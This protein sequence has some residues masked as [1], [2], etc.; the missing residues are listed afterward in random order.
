MS[1][2][3]FHQRTSR[4]ALALTALGL[5]G[6]LIGAG[7]GGANTDTLANYCQAQAEAECSIAVVQACYGSSDATLN[8][9][10]SSCIQTRSAISKCNPS[11]LPYHPEQA[12]NCIDTRASVYGA[13]KFDRAGADAIREACLPVFNKGGLEGSECTVD[14]D[15]DVGA[16]LRCITRIG[17]R[18]TCRVP[19]TVDGGSSC[20]DPAAQ[21][22]TN[23]Y[24]DDGLHCVQ[25]PAAGEKCGAGQPCDTGLRCNEVSQA[26]EKQ[27]ANGSA[28]K[29]DTDCIGGFC[30]AI[31]GT[32]GAEGQCSATFQFGFGSA[33]C[34]DFTH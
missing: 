25:R 5:G 6:G 3:N 11:N 7:C 26:C 1:L 33:T 29:L 24:C 30:I 13:G 2:F 28:C 18:G 31:N 23:Q 21:C 15:C 20:K 8:D 10:T 19:K 12:D 32:S 22:P 34:L 14:D 27:Y 16:Q 17:G 9:D 4:L